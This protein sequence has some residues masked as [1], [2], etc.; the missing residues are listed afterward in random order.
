MHQIHNTKFGRQGEK[1]FIGKWLELAF[2]WQMLV[3]AL[4]NRT[5][6]CMSCKENLTTSHPKAT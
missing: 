2:K 4:S 6:W 5:S 1:V 3:I